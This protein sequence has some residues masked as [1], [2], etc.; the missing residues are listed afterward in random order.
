MIELKDKAKRAIHNLFK[1]AVRS[2]CGDQSELVVM[3]IL[4][5]ALIYW[6][7][8]AAKENAIFQ[9]IEPPLFFVFVSVSFYKDFWE[10]RVNYF[11]L[12]M[13]LWVIFKVWKQTLLYT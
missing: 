10:I 13:S 8:S 12:C 3:P 5:Q 11:S 6:L 2:R 1:R 7:I 9:Q 4:R